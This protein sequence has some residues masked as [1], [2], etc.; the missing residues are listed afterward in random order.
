MTIALG[1]LTTPA[2][3]Q[4]RSDSLHMSGPLKP[5]RGL[6]HAPARPPWTHVVA[7]FQGAPF[8]LLQSDAKATAACRN[9]KFNQRVPNFH[10]ALFLYLGSVRHVLGWAIKD[11]LNLHDPGRLAQRDINYYFSKDQTQRCIVYIL[12]SDYSN[13]DYAHARTDPFKR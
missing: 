8:R 9:N 10:K 13:E 5:M 1:A 12:R 11:S 2:F 3:S 7:W 4:H 6:A